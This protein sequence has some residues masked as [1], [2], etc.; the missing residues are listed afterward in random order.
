VVAGFTLGSEAPEWRT[1]VSDGSLSQDEIN[2]LLTGAGVIDPPMRNVTPEVE[3]I[4][5]DVIKEMRHCEKCGAVVYEKG[6]IYPHCRAG[7]LANECM[8]E[9]VK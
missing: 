1:G 5:D 9:R 4:E 7:M 3:L 2:E 6:G 8:E